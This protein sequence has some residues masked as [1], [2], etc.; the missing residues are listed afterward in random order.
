MEKNA[1]MVPFLYKE[2]KRTPGSFRSF[3]KKGKE[4]KDRSV[5]LKRTDAQPCL[6]TQNQLYSLESSFAPKSIVQY[7]LESSFGPSPIVLF[8]IIFWSK[9]NCIVWN[10]LLAQNQLYSL[11]S[12]FGP[13]SIV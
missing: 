11:E 6:L 1:K 10:H 4:R 7:S 5:L 8:G 2:Q 13:K 12:S 9:I 3:I